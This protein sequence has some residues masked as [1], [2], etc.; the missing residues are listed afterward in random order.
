MRRKLKL[1]GHIMRMDDKRKIKGI[2][3]G[4]LRMDDKRKI[5]ELC[6]ELW[7]ELIREGDLVRSG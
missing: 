1:F 5:K 2:M 3:L 7:K 6:W 4:M